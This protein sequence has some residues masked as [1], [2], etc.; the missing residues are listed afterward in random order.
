MNKLTIMKNSE[1]LNLPIRRTIINLLIKL[2]NIFAI[3]GHFVR[4]LM[5]FFNISC[6][7]TSVVTL[8]HR[9]RD[10]ADRYRSK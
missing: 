1:S 7:V 8:L 2:V 4:I 6:D 9:D 10:I 3:L 5:T